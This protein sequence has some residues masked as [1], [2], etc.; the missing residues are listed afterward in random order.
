MRCDGTRAETR[1]HLLAKRTSPSESAGA[2]VQATTGSR[3][4]RIRGSNGSNA[5]YTTF[6]GN[7][8]STGY[9]LH[10]PVTPSLPLPCVTMYHHISTG[11]Y[12]FRRISSACGISQDLL[13]TYTQTAGR[14]MMD[15]LTFSRLMTYIYVD[16]TANLQIWHFI[17]LF[18]K[19][20]Y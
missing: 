6:W 12:H 2:S 7:V 3:G 8:K 13:D 11:L 15:G 20:T 14:A 4:V 17:Y 19:Y 16:R 18:N 10:L 9:P 5:G 1:F